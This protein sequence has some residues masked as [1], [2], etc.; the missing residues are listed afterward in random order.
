MILLLFCQAQQSSPIWETVSA[1]ILAFIGSGIV[2][3]LVERHRDTKKT[4]MLQHLIISEIERNLEILDTE[5][6]RDN[7][8]IPHKTWSSFYD[9]NSIEVTSFSDKDIAAKI[10]RFYA[11]MELL[12]IRDAENKE[13]DRLY[14]QS[15]FEA[16]ELFKRTLGESKRG[17]RNSMIVLGREIVKS[18]S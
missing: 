2:T 15:T 11:D 5:Y 7:P 18:K 12:N 4:K 16:A 14:K 10:V 6:I 8:W 9:S 3:Y 17:I 13:L 1:I